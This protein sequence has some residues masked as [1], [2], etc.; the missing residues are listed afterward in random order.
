MSPVRVVGA[1]VLVAACGAGPDLEGPR[2]PAA[3]RLV[4]CTPVQPPVVEVDGRVT[5][6]G[7]PGGDGMGWATVG[8]PPQKRVASVSLGMPSSSGML[9]IAVIRRAVAARL[10]ELGRCYERE[11]AASSNA[12]RNSVAWR[13]SVAQD[14]RVLYAS[15]TTNVM[16]TSTW[17]CV[18]SAIRSITFPAR[19][20][21]GT[22]SVTLPLTFDAIPIA[23][24]PSPL[25]TGN[26]VAWTPFAVGGLAPE[27]GATMARAA[28]RVLRARSNKVAACFQGNASGSLR[29]VLGVAGDGDVVVARAGGLGDPAVERCVE[30]DLAGVKL[31]N[32]LGEPTEI[33]CDFARGDARP[34]RVSE[35]ARYAVITA[36]RKE[37]R[38]G[39]TTLTP[40]AVEPDP[41]P[42]DAT[43]LIVADPDAPGTMI[44]NALAWASE[45]L[46]TVVALRDGTRSPLYLGM[47][48]FGHDDRQ[49]TRP[50]FRLGRGG[51]QA[52]LGK[53]VREAKLAD[54]GTLALRLAK[55]CRQLRCG[56]LVI[57]V[58]DLAVARDLVEV[59]GAARR[60]GFDR[61]LI[62]GPVECQQ[63]EELEA[64]EP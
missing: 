38:F 2:A 51:V 39:K 42:G 37:L 26:V 47:G 44:S 62:A 34:W 64:D 12:A 24:K 56:S 31:V 63:R 58:D 59:T 40:G 57:G 11:L 30:N 53:Q 10:P 32:L 3:V 18:S 27:R 6:D 36:S 55:R 52:C 8:K 33:A 43:Y 14:G 29:V 17:T 60:A 13:F 15:P 16:A 23:D 54:A 19:T 21:G 5:T 50:M 7:R 49:S 48:R 9:D 22:I 20:T 25:A 4:E 41:L 35:S 61:V 46:A 1:V 28:E 45:G